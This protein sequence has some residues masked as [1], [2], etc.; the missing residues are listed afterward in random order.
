MLLVTHAWDLL[1]PLAL[2]RDRRDQQLIESLPK[3]TGKVNCQSSD[4]ALLGFK[5]RILR[6]PV[7]CSTT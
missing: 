3:E 7:T 5:H 6:S 4:A 1:F 2:T